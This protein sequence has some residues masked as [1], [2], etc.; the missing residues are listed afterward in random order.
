[1]DRW[2]VPRRGTSPPRCPLTDF[3]SA[4]VLMPK[5]VPYRSLRRQPGPWRGN[6]LG[7]RWLGLVVRP[8]I[9]LRQRNGGFSL[10]VIFL[11]VLS[12]LT[13]TLAL[14]SRT[15][16]G[17][18]AQSYQS[19]LR[20]A[21]DA[22][23]NGLV[24]VASEFNYPGNRLVIGGGGGYGIGDLDVNHIG[25][26]WGSN[27]IPTASGD[28]DNSNKPCY[29][30]NGGGAIREDGYGP[31]EDKNIIYFASVVPNR[32]NEDRFEG[33]TWFSSINQGQA[34]DLHYLG[35]GQFYRPIDLRLYNSG[36][37]ADSRSTYKKAANN[38]VSYLAVAVE[39]F[40]AP[41]QASSKERGDIVAH[42]DVSEDKNSVKYILQQEFQVVPRCCSKGFGRVNKI[43][44]GPSSNTTDSTDCPITTTTSPTGGTTTS[45]TTTEWI[46]R[47]VSRTSAFNSDP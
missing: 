30:Y 17:L 29:I 28:S 16:G 32:E 37:T 4:I 45:Y 26:I 41:N 47:S 1:M 33:L 39:G 7:Q 42:A 27:E 46:L 11:L 12:I 2:L 36:H 3:T 6:R 14:T 31:N 8:R 24:V 10:I 40:Y 18:Y 35:N 25:A 21:K 43:A 20:L 38:Q 44:Y 15:T 5:P 22:A 34:N 19:K 9:A 23:E 13:T